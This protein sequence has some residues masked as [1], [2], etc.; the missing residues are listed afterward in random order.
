[1]KELQGKTLIAFGDSIGRGVIYEEAEG[2][3]RQSDYGFLR[4]LERECGITVENETRYGYTIKKGA[5]MFEKHKEKVERADAVLLEFGGNDC[6]FDWR[7]IAADPQGSY[8][9][10]VPLDEFLATYEA[11]VAEVCA[12]GKELYVM[13]LP[14][15]EPHRY[16]R[17]VSQ[18]VDADNILSWL[19][20]D[21]T[22]IYRWHESYST[23]LSA[24]CCRLGVTML[25]IRTAFLKEKTYGDFLCA[26][27]IHLNEKGHR[28]LFETLL[29]Q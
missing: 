8:A 21:A 29:A 26:D 12:M 4:L 17:H 1:M 22:Y 6:D 28:L 9:P 13:N 2:N 10:K 16:F 27:G 3:Y 24:L 25:D 11:L 19:G 23:A 5:R 20:G 15:I 14:P 18:G 7:A